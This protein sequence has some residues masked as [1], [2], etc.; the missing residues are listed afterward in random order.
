MQEKIFIARIGVNLLKIYIIV[1]R[2][3]KWDLNFEFF[4]LKFFETMISKKEQI[5]NVKIK[6]RSPVRFLMREQLPVNRAE[7]FILSDATP[8]GCIKEVHLAGRAGSG[9]T[10]DGPQISTRR[11]VMNPRN[12]VSSCRHSSVSL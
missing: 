9:I 6:M 8:L 5:L 7:G 1:N 4:L 2:E 11:L 12:S 10:G 3:D